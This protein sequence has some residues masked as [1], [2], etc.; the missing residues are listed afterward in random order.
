LRGRYGVFFH[1]DAIGSSFTV[2]VLYISI[3]H[4]CVTNNANLTKITQPSQLP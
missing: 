2:R 3:V 4:M 1:L